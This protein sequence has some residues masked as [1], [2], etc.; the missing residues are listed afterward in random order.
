MRLFVAID[1]DAAARDALAAVQQELRSRDSGSPIRWVRPDQLH[2]TL[3]FLGEVDE[4][5]APEL[6]V[7]I[8]AP[9]DRRA[10]D[11][12]FEGLGAFPP[13]GAPRA[14][15]VGARE[16]AAELQALQQVLAGRAARLGIRLESRPFSPHLTL[17]R[18]KASRPSDRRRALAAAPA[19]AI[20]RSHIDHA[21]LYQSRPSASGHV[22]T[23]LARANLVS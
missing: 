12:T 5:R 1:L 17:G 20:A 8:G 16:G 15:W 14:L 9:I 2:L 6:A 18:W 11:V 10:F 4:A 21:T 23:A 3:V 7:A 22:Y 19:G 13:H